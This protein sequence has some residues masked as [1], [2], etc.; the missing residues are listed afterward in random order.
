MLHMVPL[1]PRTH[2][3][4]MDKLTYAADISRLE[5]IS[6]E[7]NYSFINGDI[8]NQEIV[9]TI[10]RDDVEAVVNFAAHSH[11]DRS[12]AAP[13]DFIH[14][15][16]CGSFYLLEAARK[17]KI[18]RFLQVST[19]EVY[20]SLEE[21]EAFTEESTLAPNNPYAA[22]KAAAD[23]LVRSYCK[24]YAF[25]GMVTRC[26]NNYGPRQ[27]RE[28]FIP[29][30]IYNALQ[31]EPVPLYGD[32]QQVRDWI[33][34]ADHCRALEQ[35]LLQGKPGGVYNIGANEERTNLE[36]AGSILHILRKSPELLCFVKDRPG[37]DR[38]YALATDCIRKEL[39]W[40]PRF[41]LEVALTRTVG[42]YVNYFK[43]APAS[44]AA[45][46]NN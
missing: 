42:W 46:P 20:G 40:Q 3:V 9:D 43:S 23:C 10:M 21:K 16:I 35:V 18:K 37:H 7:A 22:S 33:F 2:F 36:L 34:V 4:N 14:T 30:V 24:T 17:F 44:F 29:T 32:G 13:L 41:D 8:I 45:A 6:G 19:D 11:V 31:D 5:A 39:G 12:I 26:T 15:N 28:K 27:H 38:R 25:P 1:Y